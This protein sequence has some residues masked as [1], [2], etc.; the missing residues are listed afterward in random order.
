MNELDIMAM[1][2]QG[3]ARRIARQKAL[4]AELNTLVGAVEAVS[5][6]VCPTGVL[7]PE[8]CM[9][10]LHA[11]FA[12]SAKYLTEMAFDNLIVRG[13]CGSSPQ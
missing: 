4:L 3:K 1:L 6:L 2:E 12:I 5:E 8:D 9:D 13:D 11:H 10:L 7:E